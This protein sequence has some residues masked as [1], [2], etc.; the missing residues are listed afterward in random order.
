MPSSPSSVESLRLKA[1]M[2]YDILDTLAEADYDAIT[3]IAAHICQTP[4]SLIS[5]VDEKRQWVKS[6][7]GISLQ[8]SAREIAFCAQ[9]IQVPDQMLVVTD[10][11][12]DERFAANPLVTGDPRI[13]FYAGVPLVDEA[14][15]A[16]GSLC[17]IDQQPRQLSPP[18]LSALQALSRQVVSLLELRR[19]QA[20]LKEAGQTL[21]TLNAE[22]RQT[23]QV[24]K[25]VV[26]TCPI[27]LVLWQA[28]RDEQTIIDFRYVLTNPVHAQ[29]A[30]V[31]SEPTSEHSLKS[32]F[33]EGVTNGLFDRLVSVVET[34]QPQHYQQAQERVGQPL[35]WTDVRLTPYEDGVL[36][37]AQDITHLKESEQLRAYTDNLTQLVSERTAEVYQLSALH[38][39]IVHHA[40][41]A[42]ISTDTSGLIQTV[43][44]AAEHLLNYQQ[45]ELIGKKDFMVLHDPDELASRARQLS[46]QVGKPVKADFDLFK[47][48]ATNQT[49][50]CTLLAKSGLRIPVLLTKTALRDEAGGV[51]GYIGMA[52]DITSQ[53]K[54]ELV[55][56]ESLQREQEL[57]RLKSQFVS[58][59]SHEFRT[60]LMTIQSSVDMIHWYLKAS[61]AGNHPNIDEH[62]G[63]IQAEI[64]NFSDLLSDILTLGKSEAG[65]VSFR[66]QWV[67]IE[68]LCQQVIATHFS[69]RKDHRSVQLLVSG[70]PGQVWVDAKLISHV[71]IN[72]LANAFKFSQEDAELHLIRSEADVCL[73]IIDKG[74]GIPSADLPSLFEAFFRAQNTTAIQGTGLGLTIARQFIDLHGGKLKVQSQEHQGTT[75]TIFLPIG[76]KGVVESETE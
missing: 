53:K 55:L 16:L 12:Q 58:T 38:H 26:S 40:G 46:E 70:P 47:V 11:Q 5:L 66:P 17:V 75:F 74:I 9:A 6:A 35:G 60:P 13:V 18:Q 61:P 8:E 56:Q 50:E 25:T 67:D 57:N 39:A 3:Q 49:Y 31:A 64:H 7:Y 34:G 4:I 20:Q 28:V 15:Y 27:E 30:G 24:L 14:G 51:T 1:L 32:Q 44:P 65:K 68:A 73:Q 21:Q 71:L 72:L 2:S 22:L 62:L 42:I 33:P 10:A 76:P 45:D 69:Q 59:A 63:V 52:T 54:I 43:N 37:T 29:Q 48:L 19:S 41:T 23:N 36:F